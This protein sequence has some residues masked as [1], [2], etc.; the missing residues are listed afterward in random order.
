M[1]IARGGKVRH[2]RLGSPLPVGVIAQVEE[3]QVG[4]ETLKRVATAQ[5]WVFLNTRK[6]LRPRSATALLYRAA[7]LEHL[8]VYGFTVL[9]SRYTLIEACDP[10]GI[11]TLVWGEVDL[12]MIT[13]KE[14]LP[15]LHEHTLIAHPHPEKLANVLKN[16]PWVTAIYFDANHY[17]TLLQTKEALI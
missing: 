17:S 14:R 11:P 5:G 10:Q 4:P 13:I 9:D 7:L 12:Q 15:K 3:H 6:S 2:P 1:T 16:Y 8:K